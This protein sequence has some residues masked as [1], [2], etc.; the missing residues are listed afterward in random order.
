MDAEA[1][2]ARIR[3]AD[4]GVVIDAWHVTETSDRGSGERVQD[5]GYRQG[6]PDGSVADEEG[7]FLDASSDSISAVAC[8]ETSSLHC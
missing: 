6:A 4:C 8:L 2:S 5:L 3:K 1:V 7:L